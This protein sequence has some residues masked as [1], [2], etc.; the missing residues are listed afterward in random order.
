[1]YKDVKSH[2]VKSDISDHFMCIAVI[3]ENLYKAK[4]NSAEKFRKITDS[5]LRNIN[6][7]LLNRNWHMLH[8]MT[9]DEGS[10]FLITEIQKLLDFYAPEKQLN[11][12]SKYKLK[13]EWVTQGL[14]VSSRK[15]LQMY[16]KVVSKPRQS[17]EFENYKKYRNLYN[18]L[19]RKAKFAH[20]N[21]L[22]KK[23]MTDAKMLWK[24]LH[25]LTGKIK[26][27]K[28][29][30]DEIIVNGIKV[31]N[32]NTI[33]DAFAKHY[34]NVGKLLA[35][36]INS[37]S[38]IKDP[39]DNMKKRVEQNCFLFP[40][41][42]GEIEKFINTL[43]EKN[44]KGHDD[45]SNRILKKIYPG[46]INALEILFNKSLQ[47]GLFPSNMKIAVV[48]PLYKSKSKTDMI[49]YRPISLLPV[50]SKILEKIVN[51]RVVKFL[52]KHKV[53]YE[54]Q[55][56]FRTNRSTTDA[57][58]DFTGNL[59]DNLN[60]G[61]YTLGLFLD[62]SKAFDSINHHTL[63][64]KLEFYG[65]RGNVLSWFKS[66]LSNR[67]LKVKIRNATSKKYLMTYGTPQG[68]V[69]GPLMYIIMANDL[70]E[71]LKF[72]NCVTFADDTT[73]FISG[74]NLKFLYR[75][76]NE[77]LKQLGDWF[78]SNSLTLNADKSKY[79]LFRTK[80]K[81]INYTGK[82]VLGGKEIN[83]VQHIKFL[84]VTIDEYLEWDRQV[85]SVLTK[86]ISGNYGI[87]MVKNIVPVKCKLLIYNSNIFSHLSY[88]LSVW[89]PMLRDKDKKKIQIQQN[90]SI[91]QI[92]NIS[93]RT[94]LLEFYKKGNIMKFNDLID[95]SLLKLSHR[96][97]YGILPIRIVNLFELGN[98][99]YATRNRQ[100]LRAMP[101][102]TQVYNK[103][104]LG[105]APNL[106]L[107]ISDP[108][109][110]KANI[111]TFSKGFTQA[112]TSSY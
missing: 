56:G 39:M 26:N 52:T 106:W 53:F 74:N 112:I 43:K 25:K 23:N 84:G 3:Q 72:S 93:K 16:K 73:I 9:V 1:M 87:S 48:K 13:A 89:G 11:C 19:R 95:L 79:I 10:K 111:K 105:R 37:K 101:H 102:T 66:Y 51:K 27:K 4:H 68:S 35:D 76:I 58:L 91:R 82:I 109:K 110:N 71:C 70:V 78:D 81:E 61:N 14:T 62:M 88:A 40:T 2:I 6:A 28:D 80:R 59:V 45:I 63:F 104:F 103:S 60:K 92:F 18:S 34:S 67:Y 41:D 33:S 29:L 97:I 77:D 83:R 31:N 54:G 108:L 5:V 98:H 57:I 64:R 75:K 94:R 55:Y 12:Q 8:D 20:Y 65:I 32:D 24:I 96:Y 38:N 107:S 36:R 86:M 17:Q 90:R 30:S 49:N 50:I 7:S 44:S 100:N 22:V 15:C 85:N 47:E 69:L 46:I 21:N 99:G 42:H